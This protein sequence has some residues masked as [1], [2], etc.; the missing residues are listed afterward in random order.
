[1][2][3]PVRRILVVFTGGTIGSMRHGHSIGLDTHAGALLFQDT[4]T[5]TLL[6]GLNI[7]LHTMAPLAM[8]SEDA[9]LDHWNRVKAAVL[10]ELRRDQAQAGPG[11]YCGVVITH[12]TDTLAVAANAFSLLLPL[13]I[14]VM[15]VGAQ[16]P[17]DYPETNGHVNFQDALRFIVEDGRAG[18]FVA[19]RNP[20]GRRLVHAG[21]LVRQSLPFEHAYHSAGGAELGEFKGESFTTLADDGAAR[22]AVSSMGKRTAVDGYLDRAC[23]SDRVLLIEPHPGLDYERFSLDGLAAVVHGV[24][25]SETVNSGSDRFGLSG[26]AARCKIL[27][28]PIFVAPLDHAAI[29]YDSTTVFDLPGVVPVPN[30]LTIMA[31]LKVSI[32]VG[33]GLTGLQLQ[34]FVLETELPIDAGV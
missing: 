32:G 2:S 4:G 9:T 13:E 5:K 14:P 19:Y 27:E 22:R 24:Y 18:T 21:S 12:G 6:T 17:L 23:L 26:L 10:V 33:M 11:A 3:H 31:Y 28:I 1:M 25:H 15:L 29:S 16:H 34:E 20:D 7:V 8:L 30:A